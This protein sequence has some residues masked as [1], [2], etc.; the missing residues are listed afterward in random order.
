MGHTAT[1][2]FNLPYGTRI[3]IG[4]TLLNPAYQLWDESVYPNADQFVPD[5]FLKMQQTPGSEAYHKLWPWS[6][7]VSGSDF[8]CT[9]PTDYPLSPSAELGLAAGGRKAKSRTVWGD[10][11]H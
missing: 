6:S 3:A 2:D 11:D 8:C 5:R 1:R 4:E 7:F 10:D 9:S